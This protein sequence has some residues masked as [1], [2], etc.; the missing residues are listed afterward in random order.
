MKT[1]KAIVKEFL[2]RKK[3][4]G[5]SARAV[6]TSEPT[7]HNQQTANHPN[8]ARD[9]PTSEPTNHNQQTANLPNS[10]RAV[11]TSKQTN[12]NQ[13][14]TNH[15][16]TTR[17]VLTSKTTINSLTLKN[18]TQ[19]ET[20]NHEDPGFPGMDNPDVGQNSR[21]AEEQQREQDRQQ[22]ER[23]MRDALKKAFDDGVKAGRNSKIEELYFPK[24]EDGIPVFH[25]NASKL[26]C[27]SDIFSLA[28]EA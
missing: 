15:P 8:S 1:I 17:A 28:R 9:V 21:D 11:P 23:E 25:G 4:A 14:T 22:Q 26:D 10:A 18:Q 20:E 3:N 7:N 19:N 24:G 16:N 5:N 2:S 27:E 12:H 6:P 13:Q